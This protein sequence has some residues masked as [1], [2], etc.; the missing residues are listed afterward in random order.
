MNYSRTSSSTDGD[1]ATVASAVALSGVFSS[2]RS[3]LGASSAPSI[4]DHFPHITTRSPLMM[5]VLEEARKF[6]ASENCVLIQGE[7]GTGKEL[8]AAS[9]HRLSP[10]SSEK[11]VTMNCSAIPE[12]LL[13]SELFGHVRGAFT[14]ADRHKEGF[15][16]K[17][18]GGTLFLDEIGDMPLRLQAKLLRVLQNQTYH[19]VGSTELKKTD[20]RIIAAT[21]VDLSEAVQ[22]KRFRLDLYYRLNILPIEMP[23]LRRRAEDIDLLVDEFMTKA[24]EECCFSVAC[25]E[26]MRLYSW[27]GNIRELEN[28]ITRLMITK[29]KGVVDVGDLPDKYLQEDLFPLRNPAHSDPRMRQN[30]LFTTS[31]DYEGPQEGSTEL[32]V[33]AKSSYLL[34]EMI[35]HITLPAAGLCMSQELKKLEAHLMSKA[36]AMTGNNKN[37]AASLLGMKRTTLVEKMKRYETLVE[38]EPAGGASFMS[39]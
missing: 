22:R 30:S 13:E 25:R 19:P 28:L 20:V 7:S 23:P 38:K 29:G 12:G 35:P 2:V 24:S 27:P 3:R 33:P 1:F 8:M 39:A 26:R 34:S 37:K 11:L 4:C 5:R 15:F 10:R 14:G 16:S 17:A 31:M 18:Q 32:R 6:A 21:N 9:V 36:M